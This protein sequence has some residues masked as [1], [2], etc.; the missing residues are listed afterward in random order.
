M[1]RTGTITPIT[2][3]HEL[4]PPDVVELDESSVESLA[5]TTCD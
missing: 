3:G 4:N 2:I 1:M 5:L